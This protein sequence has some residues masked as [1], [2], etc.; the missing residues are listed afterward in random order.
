MR[1]RHELIR[2]LRNKRGTSMTKASRKS[3]VSVCDMS[4]WES[5]KRQPLAKNLKQLADFFRVD[6][7]IFFE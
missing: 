5:G 6:M 3:G 2:E 4:L 7:E 1:F